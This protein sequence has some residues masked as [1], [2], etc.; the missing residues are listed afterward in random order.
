MAASND[1]TASLAWLPDK[2]A[3]SA[4]SSLSRGTTLRFV[5]STGWSTS[6]IWLPI[7]VGAAP[8][9][10]AR[11]RRFSGTLVF[12]MFANHQSEGI[13]SDRPSRRAAIAIALVCAESG[14]Y[15]AEA[16]LNEAVNLARD[17]GDTP[18]IA[19]IITSGC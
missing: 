9:P 11:A 2:W 15:E 14:G 13:A 12:W 10:S 5:K 16:L 8:R 17:R 7:S 19:R 4:F 18:A 1:G 6:L 3:V